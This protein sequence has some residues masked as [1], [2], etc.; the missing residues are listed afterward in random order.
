[1]TDAKIWIRFDLPGI[2]CYPNAPEEVAYLRS[3]HR[4]LFKFKITIS[5]YHDDREI[6]YHMFMNWIKSLYSSSV[7]Q[8]DYKSCEHI[9]R[10][11]LE[12]VIAKYPGRTTEV[13]V[14][15]DGECGSIVRYHNE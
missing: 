11:L 6:E 8:L 5:V 14:S 4:H 1:M 10:E 15:E 7:L 9:A 12:Q 2:H 3:P 13:E